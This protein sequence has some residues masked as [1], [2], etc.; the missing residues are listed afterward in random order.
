MQLTW[1]AEPIISPSEANQGRS[2]GVT[3]PRATTG[4]NQLLKAL[5]IACIYPKEGSAVHDLEY[6]SFIIAI[7]RQN[8]INWLS[9]ARDSL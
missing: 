3:D 5:M 2:Q 1:A 7:Y 6:I 9:P 8:S 4:L